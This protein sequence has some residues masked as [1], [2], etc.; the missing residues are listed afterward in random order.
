M[1][2]MVLFNPFMPGFTDDPYPH[3]R[4]LRD[5]APVQEHPLGFWFL[6]RHDDVA[7]LLRRAVGGSGADSVG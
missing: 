7:D 1:T 2:E 5:A 6:S 4:E 3:Y